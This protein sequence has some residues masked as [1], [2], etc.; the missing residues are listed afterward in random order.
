MVGSLQAEAI[1]L[2]VTNRGSEPVRRLRFALRTAIPGSRVRSI[3]FRGVFALE[4][5]GEALELAE[6]VCRQCSEKIGH[7]TAV[8]A[9]VESREEPIKDAATRIGAAQIGSRESFC[10]RL[11]KRGAHGL[12]QNTS[13]LEQEIGGAIWTALQAK[14]GEKPKVSLK[15]PDIT[16]TA[17]ILGSVAAVGISREVWFGDRS[18]LRNTHPVSHF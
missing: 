15:N 14:Y 4:A 10:F 17:E 11:H 2:I 6:L 3:G 16:I 18:A 8:L 9:V 12:E 7:V 1:K 13:K 5:A